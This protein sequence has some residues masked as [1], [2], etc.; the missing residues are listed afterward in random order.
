M[1]VHEATPVMMSPHSR[2]GPALPTI[3]A[4]TMPLAAYPAAASGDS[5][6]RALFQAFRRRWPQALGLGVLMGLLGAGLTWTL[7]PPQYNS[8]ATLHVSSQP[9]RGLFSV[10]D[11]T[12]D[13]V[14][15]QRT[16]AAILRS[17]EVLEGALRQP[18]V[19]ERPTISEEPQPVAWLAQNLKVESKLGPEILTVSLAGDHAD[20]LPIIVNAVVQSYIQELATKERAKQ[21]VRVEQLQENYR[22]L[23]ENLRRKRALLRELETTL[24]IDPPQVVTLRYQSALNQLAATEKEV[25]Q[26]RIALKN[27]QLELALMKQKDRDLS[28][29]LEGEQGLELLLVQDSSYQMTMQRKVKLEEELGRVQGLAAPGV[30]ERMMQ[31][32]MV[33]VAALDRELAAKRKALLPVL[34]AQ[35]RARLEAR[36][37]VLEG[38]Y[39]EVT[40]EM[41]K[42]DAEVKRL[43]T[44]IRQ[45]DRPTSDVESLRDEVAQAEQVLKK[46]GEQRDIM[47][48]EPPL[49]LRASVL[50]SATT[51]QTM[52]LRRHGKFAGLIGLAL[53]GL[54]AL[55][56]C[57]TEYRARRIHVEDDVVRG[58]GMSVLGCLPSQPSRGRLTYR[59]A[60]PF[61]DNVLLTVSVDAIRQRL[62][63]SDAEAMRVVMIASAKEDEGKSHLAGQLASSLARSGYKVLLL[64]GDLQRRAERPFEGPTGPGFGELLR[65]EA[66]LNEA[67]WAAPLHGLWLMPLGQWSDEAGSIL[68]HERG[69]LLFD[70]LRGR[71]DFVIVD[72]SPV[73]AA[74]ESL[75]LA[76]HANAVIFA[77]QSGV[78]QI[79][80]VQEA[81]Q[82][83]QRVGVPVLGAVVGSQQGPARRPLLA[84]A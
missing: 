69:A 17:R 6:E 53:F 52:D 80:L 25:L 34:L 21:P 20:D 76:Q 35:K 4:P 65:G 1:E 54:T 8:Q 15:Y 36:A 23:E 13:F 75:L 14:A 67:E 44:L 55:G 28:G 11:G 84:N 7:L 19:A 10:P 30:R 83:V 22:R 62:L 82:L 41:K 24:G 38:Q 71:Y 78:S 79:P 49:P 27:A 3:A 39:K 60:P 70:L 57:F 58:L 48:V 37:N 31:D 5:L 50:E 77:V 33:Q 63:Q 40:D 66:R 59:T 46:V 32:H 12:E 47:K 43:A 9:T 61:S 72:A 74:S 45:P 64:D 81:Q 26:T 2:R 68:A 42:Q 73:L 51:P 56:V 29:F 16:Q 18:A